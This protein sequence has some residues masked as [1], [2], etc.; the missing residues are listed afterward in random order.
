[1]V[2]SGTESFND[3]DSKGNSRTMHRPV[4]EYTYQ[5]DGRAYRGNQIQLMMQVSGSQGYAQK[6]AGKYPA[7]SAVTVLYDPANPGNAALEKP[8]GMTWIIL[9][10]ALVMFAL[11]AWQFGIFK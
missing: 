9:A 8:G 2:S 7:G 10:V 5:V 4:V 1:M 6:K 3:T 11:A